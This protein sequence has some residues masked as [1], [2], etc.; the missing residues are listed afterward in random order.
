MHADA[1]AFVRSIERPHPNLLKMYFLQALVTLF[2]FP[3]TI[4]PLYFRYH[5]LRYKFDEEGI[6]ARWGIIFHR[7]VYL[8]Y[9]RIQDIHVTRNLFERWLGIGKVAIQ[10]AAGSSSAELT[11]EGMEHYEAVR[12][13]LYAR[14]RG[15]QPAG[16]PPSASAPP[17]ES[18]VVALL[19]SIQSELEGARRALEGRA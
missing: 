1:G 4:V 16:A 10:T 11:L 9:R 3:I 17:V 18:D 8:T 14:M 19:R 15:T 7:E 2:A 13:W 5:T 12:D 6:S